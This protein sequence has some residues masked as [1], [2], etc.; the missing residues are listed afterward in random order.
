VPIA[1][2][3]SDKKKLKDKILDLED[4]LSKKGD[5]SKSV[6]S[7]DLKEL[8]EE[9]GVD[10]DFVTKLAENI[11]SKNKLPEDVQKKL[12]ILSK[13]S[14]QEEA[15]KSF[16]AAVKLLQ[17]ENP[18]EPIMA[19]K[20]KIKELGYTEGHTTESAYEL[21]FRHVKTSPTKKKKTAE[22]TKPNG[23]ISKEVT[24][25]DDPNLDTENLSDSDFDKF[26][27]AQAAK[28]KKYEIK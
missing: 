20:E 7:K 13:K 15:D 11:S 8:A 21:Y 16:D 1:K 28:E 5:D 12:D 17:D 10:E 27:D 18:N 24:D 9:Y 3:L 2:Y 22:K 23:E 6:P 4:K 26:S 25:F 14:E 19:N